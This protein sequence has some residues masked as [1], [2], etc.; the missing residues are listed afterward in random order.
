[1][2][3]DIEMSTNNIPKLLSFDEVWAMTQETAKIIQENAKQA[4]EKQQEH[5]KEIAEMREILKKADEQS[6]EQRKKHEKEIAEIREILKQTDKQIKRTG[7]QIG[8]LG[9]RFG[10][11]AEHLV[12]PRI[13]D[14]FNELN[15]H[16]GAA[17]QNFWVRGDN[18]QILAEIDIMLVNDDFV[19]CIE[20]KVKPNE[21]D[22]L[23]HIER[24]KIVHRYYKKRSSKEMKVIGAIAGTIFSPNLVETIIN[25]GLYLVVP[26]GNSFK[27]DVPK[28]FQPQFFYS[29]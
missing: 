8:D 29:E 18:D 1:M 25:N 17:T 27:I 24:L 23:E 4:R 11:V 14:K 13:E 15:Y 3:G 5:D 2:K 10:R 21:A 19:L 6:I 9:N 22:V 7:K 28:N 20:V 12:A 26:S 16:F